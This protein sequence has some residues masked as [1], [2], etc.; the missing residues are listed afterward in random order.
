MSQVTA[1]ATCRTGVA[2]GAGA[3]TVFAGK[4]SGDPGSVAGF[5]INKLSE[6]GHYGSLFNG[7]RSLPSQCAPPLNVA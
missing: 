6:F 4:Q 2:G 5:A 7:H 3:H 1:D